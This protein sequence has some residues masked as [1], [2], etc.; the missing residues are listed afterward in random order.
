M[1]EKEKKTRFRD[2]KA[3]DY[4]Y[5]IIGLWV[6]DLKVVKIKICP[7]SMYIYYDPIK[8]KGYKSYEI[9]HIYVGKDFSSSYSSTVCTEKKDAWEKVIGDSQAR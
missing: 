5:M 8:V 7:K 1:N 3:G 4:V 2:L 6:Y 9:D